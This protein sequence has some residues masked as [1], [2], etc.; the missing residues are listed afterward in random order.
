MPVGDDFGGV[1]LDCRYP[2]RA[3]AEPRCPECGRLFE[4]TNP[5]SYWLP[6]MVTAGKFD[7]FVGLGRPIAVC[8]LATAAALLASDVYPTGFPAAKLFGLLVAI[9]GA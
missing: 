4:P 2:L 1:C 7:I 5:R 3:L 8:A 9:P 6:G